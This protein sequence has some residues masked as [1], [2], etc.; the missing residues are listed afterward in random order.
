MLP[1]MLPFSI[2]TASRTGRKRLQI[3]SIQRELNA[4]KGSSMKNTSPTR[5]VF[6]IILSI[7]FL[8]LSQ[9]LSFG[10][11]VTPQHLSFG[12]VA[13]GSSATLT[14]SIT[15]DGRR[16][17]VVESAAVSGTAFNISTPSLPITLTPGESASF[18]VKF[19]P[20]SS[21]T[22]DGSVLIK[23]KRENREADTS[24]S[25]SDSIPVSGTGKGSETLESITISPTSASIGVGA[26]KAF[27]ATG[28]YSDGSTQ[29]LTSTA[30]WSSTVTSVAAVSAGLATAA[31]AGSTNIAAKSGSVT[32]SAALLTVAAATTPPV[33]QSITLN[34]PSA[35]ISVGGTAQVSATGHYSDGS[36]QNLT[37]T[38]SWSSTVTSVAAVSAGLATAAAAGSTNIA[39]KSGSVTSSAAGLTVSAVTT[40]GGNTYYV[41]PS[42]NDSNPG[43]NAAPWLTIQ[44]A[45]STV[46]AGS[47][48]YVEPG[49]YNES[50]NVTVSGTSS[51][52]ITFIGQ[53]GAIVGGTGLT[54]TTSQ[55]Q[56]LWN[57][58]S[59]TPAGVDVSY[60]TI[61][62]FTIENYTTSNA[63][64]TPAGIWI[65]GLS[66][67]IIS[68]INK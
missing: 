61:Q 53:S 47:T 10:Q 14:L 66:K 19:T 37:S 33:L 62:G 38:A 16:K 18:V 40:G 30:T 27:T 31:A 23:D 22:F 20:T 29:N 9:N 50:I 51:A 42:G 45:A 6:A 2:L 13:V 48:V 1:Q 11:R 5:H 41:S 68:L 36:T 57:I 43:T 39:A 56:G 49:T 46:A 28:H 15:A 26:T 24:E 35:S 34:P 8:V 58:G 32:S 21:E 59:A 25:R 60:V 55:T 7:S 52:P 64:A 3:P 54:P 63:N 12:N 4:G 44:H 67:G 17:L 65:W